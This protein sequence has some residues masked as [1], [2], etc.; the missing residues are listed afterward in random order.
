MP[1]KPSFNYRKTPKGWLVNIPASVSDTGRY[2]RRY[3]KTRDEAKN[4]CAR[5]RE[6]S[7]GNRYKASDISPA[8]A[9]D[10]IRAKEIL[11]QHDATLAQV[12]AYYVEQHDK[13]SKAPTLTD[14]WDNAIRHREHHR[15]STLRDFKAWQRALPKWL[16]QMNT[17]DISHHDIT[18][19]LNETTK[20]LTRWRSGRRYISAVIT[21]LASNGTIPSNPAKAVQV[22]RRPEK[23]D[24]ISIYSPKELKDLFKACKDYPE[25]ERDRLCASCAIPF[26]FMAFA[27]IRPEEITKL[28]W[29]DVS[30]ELE[31][32]RI[33]AHVAKKAYRRNVRINPTLAAWISTVPEDK[34]TGS[35]VP[36][37]WRYKAAKV[38]KKAG[39]DG[40]EKQ[41]ALRHSYG[42]FMLATENDLDSLKADM[43][44]HHIAVFFEHYHKAMTKKE[45][46]PYWSVL[47][48]GIDK[49]DS[50]S[51]A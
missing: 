43:G 16:M 48:P 46:L 42:S 47:P 25:G 19:A 24:E 45:A 40:R 26:A 18:K 2:R 49:I 28:K 11:A 3:F 44:H 22:K 17:F 15:A 35:I 27:G 51:V 38:R 21:P 6:I 14:A 33:G 29:K 13:R 32:I 9:E 34:R 41:D 1:R 50:I 7:E 37:R 4:E 23:D 36:G 5:L 8:L 10:A 30:V 20:G 39:F 31:N 12:A